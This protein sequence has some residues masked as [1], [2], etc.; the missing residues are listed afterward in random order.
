MNLLGSDVLVALQKG[1]DGSA[2]RQ[3]AIANNIA[4]I[5][6]PGY[7][8]QDVSF[9]SELRSALNMSSNTLN[10]NGT[11][12]GHITQNSALS[13]V[14]PRIVR[15]ES[16]SMRPDENNVDMDLEMAKMAANA[17]Y[18]NTLIRQVNI[19]LAM[20]KHTISEGRR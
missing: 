1:L 13:E 6:T 4:N 16:Q 17:L 2:A 15:E 7:K 20:L 8:R 18:Y 14:Q 9:K 3:Q 19:R 10:M 5:N 11:H 12:P